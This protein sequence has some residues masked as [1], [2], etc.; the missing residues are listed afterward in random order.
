MLLVIILSFLSNLVF[1]AGGDMVKIIAVSSATWVVETVETTGQGGTSGGGAAA[2]ALGGA[3]WL[4]G[5][6]AI[7][8]GALLGNHVEKKVNKKG[9]THTTSR[10]V[11]GYCIKLSN[12]ESLNTLV[13]YRVGQRIS[14]SQIIEAN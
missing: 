4:G 3:I 9:E 14:R 6:V 12:G 11:Q 8:G 5:P 10:T 2:G 1:A 13:R 7:V